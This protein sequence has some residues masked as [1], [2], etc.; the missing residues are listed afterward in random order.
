MTNKEAIEI[1]QSGAGVWPIT[2]RANNAVNKA[3]RALSQ[4]R[5]ILPS[6]KLPEA[7]QQCLFTVEAFHWANE[8]VEY[9]VIQKAYN[10]N[11]DFIAWMPLPEP[12]KAESEG[13]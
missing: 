12:Y 11:Q 7:F 5:W 6:E 13:V 3:I 8:P 2:D 4:T 9:I 10:G 1:L